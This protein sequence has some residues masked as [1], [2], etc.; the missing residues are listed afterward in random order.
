MTAITSS[1]EAPS[2]GTYAGPP[3]SRKRPN[4]S[5][6]VCDVPPQRAAQTPPADV[7]HCARVRVREN[8]RGIDR[9]AERG[10]TIAHLRDAS[11]PIGA[12]TIE[13]L[14]QQATTDR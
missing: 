7:Q 2:R 1:G 12:L 5:S 6:R 9:A 11:E 4:A 3:N 14:A 8:R 13:E 10:E